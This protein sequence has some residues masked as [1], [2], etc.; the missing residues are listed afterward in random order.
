MQEISGA[1]RMRGGAKDCTLVVFQNF[2]PALDI[3][4]VFGAGFGSQGKIGTKESCAKFGNQFL[5]GISFIAP[6]LA[7]EFPVQ[8]RLVFRPV[9]LMPNSA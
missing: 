7:S 6:T 8:P 4:G 2:E 1:L 5:A 3:G 9:P